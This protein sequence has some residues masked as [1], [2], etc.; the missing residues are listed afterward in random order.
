[1][2]A[3]LVEKYPRLANGLLRSFREVSNGPEH[4]NAQAGSNLSDLD[5]LRLPCAWKLEE[6][7]PEVLKKM[8]LNGVNQRTNEL[9]HKN[10][11]TCYTTNP[12]RSK[13]RS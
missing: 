8:L 6:R 4:S 3:R 1:M 13:S 5:D 11:G 2:E 10:Q 12:A 9:K 7:I